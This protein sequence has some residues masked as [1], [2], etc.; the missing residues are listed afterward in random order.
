MACRPGPSRSH[1]EAFLFM[2]GAAS[3]RR[4]FASAQDEWSDDRVSLLRAEE[5]EGARRLGCPGWRAST[6][7]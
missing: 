4:R 2:R 6:T 3:Q 7:C 5:G 1:T